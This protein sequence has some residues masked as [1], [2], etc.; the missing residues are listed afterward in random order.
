V[1]IPTRG[2]IFVDEPVLR[3]KELARYFFGTETIYGTHYTSY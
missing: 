1:V 3:L 2:Q